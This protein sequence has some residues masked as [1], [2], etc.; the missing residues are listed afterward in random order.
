MFFHLFQLKVPK[1]VALY[2]LFWAFAGIIVPWVITEILIEL[3]ICKT[4]ESSS[5]N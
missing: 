3:N 1:A 4:G 2:T 5:L